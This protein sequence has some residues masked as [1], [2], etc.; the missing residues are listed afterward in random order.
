[1]AMSDPVEQAIDDVASI[2]ASWFWCSG[3]YPTGPQLEQLKLAL[4]KLVKVVVEQA[5]AGR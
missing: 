2:V 5:G 4:R 1:M 3:Y